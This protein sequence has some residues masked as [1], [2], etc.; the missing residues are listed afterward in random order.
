MGEQML[1]VG[2]R[3]RWRGA[4]GSQPARLA[5]VTSIDETDRPHEKYGREVQELPWARVRADYCTVGL[6][7]GHWAYG[8]QLDPE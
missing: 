8:S 3:V 5:V 4:W 1:R 7:N 6:N 2:D